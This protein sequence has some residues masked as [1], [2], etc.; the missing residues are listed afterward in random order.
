M[1]RE[2]ESRFQGMRLFLS[3]AAAAPT[4]TFPEKDVHANKTAEER[5]LLG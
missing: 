1:R 4:L 3:V 2:R 5:M